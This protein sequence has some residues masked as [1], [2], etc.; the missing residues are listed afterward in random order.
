MRPFVR[1]TVEGCYIF[2]VDSDRG[3]GR[4]DVAVED[5]AYRQ[6][7]QQVDA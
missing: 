2:R 3:E 6:Y 1:D 5:V 7:L 4:D